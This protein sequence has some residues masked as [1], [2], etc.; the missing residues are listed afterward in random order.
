MLLHDSNGQMRNANLVIHHDMGLNELIAVLLD[1][2]GSAGLRV[3]ASS[4]HSIILQFYN[5]TL[6]DSVPIIATGPQSTPIVI[7]LMLKRRTI[8][9]ALGYNLVDRHPEILHSLGHVAVNTLAGLQGER[10]PAAAMSSLQ[11]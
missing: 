10:S 11:H 8:V 6:F 7:S 4:L 3:G 2:V 5:T 9:L 1:P